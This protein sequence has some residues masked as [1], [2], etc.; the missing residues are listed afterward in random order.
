MLLGHANIKPGIHDRVVD[1]LDPFAA[2]AFGVANTRRWALGRAG[3]DSDA[4][5]HDAAAGRAHGVLSDNQASPVATVAFALT[6][7]LFRG[8]TA[9]F[10]APPLC[11][12]G[13]VALVTSESRYHFCDLPPALLALPD[14]LV[15][16]Y[17]A[18][19]ATPAICPDAHLPQVKV[20]VEENSP[21]SFGEPARPGAAPVMVESPRL[22]PANAAR[23][24]AEASHQTK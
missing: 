17:G 12:N 11:A 15:G 5:A 24:I 6:N 4:L 14:Y 22:S 19:G 9:S 1:A 7:Q 13:H 18:A 21:P 16:A 2:F 3:E 23:V 10:A 8:Q 20:F